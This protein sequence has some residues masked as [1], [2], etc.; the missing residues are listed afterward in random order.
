MR[1]TINSVNRD[2]SKQKKCIK[3]SKIKKKKFGDIIDIKMKGVC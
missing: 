2:V 3:P 1:I